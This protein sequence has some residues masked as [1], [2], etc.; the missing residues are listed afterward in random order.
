MPVPQIIVLA[1]DLGRRR[2]NTVADRVSMNACHLLWFLLEVA[3]DG[4]VHTDRLRQRITKSGHGWTEEQLASYLKE[5]GKAGCL[6]E[7]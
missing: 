6:S 3:E 7:H 4:Q 2:Y 1:P 5:L